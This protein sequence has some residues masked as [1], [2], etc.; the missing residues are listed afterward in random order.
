MPKNDDRSYKYT[1]EIVTS[2]GDERLQTLTLVQ[3]RLDYKN[4][5]LVQRAITEAVANAML[6]LGEKRAKEKHEP[7]PA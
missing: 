6:S 2:K 3:E 1:V 5:V 7:R 4:L